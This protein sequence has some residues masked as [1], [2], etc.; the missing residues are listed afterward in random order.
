MKPKK[1]KT[2]CVSFSKKSLFGLIYVG[3][4]DS[5]NL[6]SKGNVGLSRLINRLVESH[7]T[8]KHDQAMIEYYQNIIKE[9]N[10]KAE[11]KVREYA[12]E[13]KKIKAKKVEKVD[14]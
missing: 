4:L 5:R 8:E 2:W 6:T 1:K 14:I 13:I 7:V 3:V 10:D 11:Q 9:T 12:E